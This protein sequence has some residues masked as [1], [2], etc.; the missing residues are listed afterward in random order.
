L[1]A[2]AIKGLPQY[3]IQL[4]KEF[5]QGIRS[6]FRFVGSDQLLYSLTIKGIED[7]KI[8]RNELSQRLAGLDPDN[9]KAMMLHQVKKFTFSGAKA[10]YHFWTEEEKKEK[11]KEY[12]ENF[13]ARM[14]QLF[15]QTFRGK[16][17]V[18]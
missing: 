15:P 1:H 7:H 2:F 4:D 18:I 11:H 14:N 9:K 6:L 16:E 17:P 8:K 10:L 12:R 5:Y 13:Q 3:V